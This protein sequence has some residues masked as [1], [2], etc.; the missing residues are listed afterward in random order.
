[1]AV[2]AVRSDNLAV[3]FKADHSPVTE[4][5]QRSQDIVI[6]G[7]KAMTPGIP[8][9][10]EEQAVAPWEERRHWSR[11]WLVDPLDG[12]RGFVSGGDEFVI[13]LALVD[14]GRPVLGLICHP[15]SGR[16][17]VAYRREAETPHW[18]LLQSTVEGQLSVLEPPTDRG[19][20][21][22]VLVGHRRGDRTLVGLPRALQ[23][24][25][26][27]LVAVG[28]AYK[29]LRMALGDGD[30]HQRTAPTCAWDTAAGQALLEAAGGGLCDLTGKP[31]T[32]HGSASLLNP[33]FYAYG[34]RLRALADAGALAVES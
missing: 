11:L 3:R 5:D 29:Y 8:I 30:F 34:P 21:L 13:N 7:L 20:G 31:L 19:A 9:I 4:A 6:A 1:M 14:G 16:V 2:L 26:P 33:G 15:V 23:R 10:S 32:Y 17:L 27:T 24:Q 18:Q 25:Q 28:S 12:T 22:Q